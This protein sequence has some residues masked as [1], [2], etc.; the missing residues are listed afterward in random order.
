VLI[1]RHGTPS[2]AVD[3]T[4]EPDVIGGHHGAVSKS[5]REVSDFEYEGTW[6]LI[7]FWIGPAH[8]LFLAVAEEASVLAQEPA[9]ALG[10]V[11]DSGQAAC[12]SMG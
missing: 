2:R 6:T 11:L 10:P 5:L 9:I 8:G 3:D 4:G 12:L 7:V 1:V